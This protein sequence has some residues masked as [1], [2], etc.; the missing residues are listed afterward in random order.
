VCAFSTAIA[1]FVAAAV[2]RLGREHPGW[3]IEI[4][5]T[6]SEESLALLLDREAD[7]AVVMI[8]P[9]RPLLADRRISLEPLVAERYFAVLPAQHP[10]AARAGELDLAELAR[11]PWIQSRRWTSCHEVVAAACAAAGFQPRAAHHAACRRSCP[12]PYGCCRSARPPRCATSPSRS[13]V[14]PA[15]PNWCR[16]CAK[17]RPDR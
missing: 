6:E 1:G 2:A 7:A 5:E 15:T 17:R 9:N 14:A 13:G 16:L 11:E 3:G 8:A 12:I 4:E 10:L